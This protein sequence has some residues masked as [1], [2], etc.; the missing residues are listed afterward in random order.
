MINHINVF[1]LLV[2]YHMIDLNLLTGEMSDN[3]SWQSGI[4]WF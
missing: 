4:M 2:G 3:Q 1:V